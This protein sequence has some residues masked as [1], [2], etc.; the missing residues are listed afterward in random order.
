MPP[1]KSETLTTA[2]IIAAYIA[3]ASWGARTISS[4]CMRPHSYQPTN[5]KHQA[6]SN[7][8]CFASPS[9]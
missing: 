4:A 7:L 1:K 9:L 2:T 5:H 6:G 3:A 8:R